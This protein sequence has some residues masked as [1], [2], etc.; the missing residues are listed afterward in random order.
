MLLAN[1]R[2]V[3]RMELKMIRR[4]CFLNIYCQIPKATAIVRNVAVGV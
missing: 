2:R 3:K 1:M 4:F